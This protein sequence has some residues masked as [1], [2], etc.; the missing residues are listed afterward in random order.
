MILPAMSIKKGNAGSKMLE[1]SP[2]DVTKPWLVTH[3]SKRSLIPLILWGVFAIYLAY[4]FSVK[5][6]AIYLP[7][8]IP[9]LGG[10]RLG[11]MWLLPV[12]IFL[13]VI[14]RYYNDLYIFETTRITHQQGRL[15][16]RYSVPVIKYVHIRAIAINQSLLGRLLNY[17]NVSF[18]TAA[19]EGNELIVLGTRDPKALAKAVDYL[20]LDID[21]L[22]NKEAADLREKALDIA[23]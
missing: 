11:T 1:T 20:R 18:G 15:S 10:I 2:F 17:G 7:E 12:S 9:Y 3:R 8:S 22:T 4:L 13:E 14:R 19:E 5:A 16:L 23:S 21:R 6:P